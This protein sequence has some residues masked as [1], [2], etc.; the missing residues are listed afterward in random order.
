MQIMK[1]RKI[2]IFN[3]M[4]QAQS[5]GI[6]MYTQQ[7]VPPPP[8]SCDVINGMPFVGILVNVYQAAESAASRPDP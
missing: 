7:A 4:G 5:W 1:A 6:F 2:K 3:S 8:P